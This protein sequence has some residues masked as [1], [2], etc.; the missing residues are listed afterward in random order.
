M[1][2][3]SNENAQTRGFWF[4]PSGDNRQSGQSAETAKADPQAAIDAALNLSP[5]P[6][7]LDPAQV[8]AS[9]GGITPSGFVLPLGVSMDA[10]NSSFIVSGPVGIDIG[11]SLQCT[12]TTMLT[13]SPN[14]IGILIDGSTLASIR[15]SFLGVAG[16]NSTCLKV[17]GAADKV[18]CIVS[19]IRLDQP[20]CIG[21]HDQT[22]NGAPEI[23]NI[24]EM[25]LEADNCCAF[26]Y[27]PTDPLSEATLNIGNISELGT[28]TGT[29]GIEGDNGRLSVFTND[30]TADTAI[31]VKSGFTLDIICT[32][33]KGRIIVEAGGVVNCSIRSYVGIIT[34]NGEINGDI[35]D[36]TFGNGNSESTTFKSGGIITQGSLNTQI[37]ITPVIGTIYDYTNPVEVRVFPVSTGAFTDIDLDFVATDLFSTIAIDRDGNVSQFAPGGLKF[38]QRRDFIVIGT[39]SHSLGVYQVSNSNYIAARETHAQ[40]LDLLA[41]LGV[42]KCDGLVVQP[43]SD[44]SFDKTAGIVMNPGAGNITGNRAENAA[45]IAAE[46]PTIFSRF[47]G[48]TETTVTTGQTQLDPDNY[49]DGSGSPASIGGSP[50]QSTIMYVFQF[51]LDGAVVVQYGQTIYADLED[52]V[53]QA[54]ADSP[55]IPDFVRQDALL[56]VRIAVERSATDL[57]DAAQVKFLPGAKFGI[58][59]TGGSGGSGAGGGDVFGPASS[60]ADEIPTYADPT[61]KVIQATS[62]ISA[63]SGNIQR[64]TTDG[65]LTF[66]RNGTGKVHFGNGAILGDFGASELVGATTFSIASPLG[67]TAT[68]NYEHNGSLAGTSGFHFVENAIAL[69]DTPTG[70]GIYIETDGQI[71]LGTQTVEPDFSVFIGSFT[72]PLGL[73]QLNNAQEGSITGR[74]RMIHY[75]SIFESIRYWNQNENAFESLV[76]GP[77]GPTADVIPTF[78][79]SVGSRLSTNSD[80]S[81]NAG[82]MQRITNNQSFRINRSGTG[83]VQLGAGSILGEFGVVDASPNVRFSVASNAPTGSMFITFE[84]NSTTKGIIGFVDAE[85]TFGIST[86]DGG[87]VFVN[88]GRT[89]IGIIPDTIPAGVACKIGSSGINTMMVPEIGQ[90]VENILTGVTGMFHFN[91]SNNRLRYFDGFVFQSIANLTETLNAVGVDG[92][93]DTTLVSGTYVDVEIPTLDFIGSDGFVS[94]VNGVEYTGPGF[95]GDIDIEYTSKSSPSVSAAQYDFRAFVFPTVPITTFFVHKAVSTTTDMQ[96]NLYGH[97]ITLNTGDIIRLRCKGNITNSTTALRDIKFTAKAF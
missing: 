24:N 84:Q 19:Q 45:E 11:S 23:Y 93:T 97:G 39:V 55:V 41:C 32:Q 8:T 48:I 5:P 27:E 43:N 3:K 18:F 68:V 83:V 89:F 13:L 67:F 76:S 79:G 81:I 14:A 42:I 73:P 61:G 85:N 31:L 72:D 47:L 65:D 20:G 28:N 63:D 35:N 75:N 58:D 60:I 38:I 78:H 49:D 25:T 52:A 96:A 6:G 7:A 34:N 95:T 40:F 86:A 9:Q 37:D 88:A 54:D 56:V 33:M 82:V 2:F 46:S 50:N 16:I 87:G 29:I 90:V 22:S 74:P 77:D 53:S 59:V 10:A 17:T 4:A 80:V 36:D 57:T 1:A 94:A 70:K 71:S 12:I 21:V 66:L 69:R 51:P 15:A 62:D 91:T 64:I 92:G 44:L 30:I 26:K